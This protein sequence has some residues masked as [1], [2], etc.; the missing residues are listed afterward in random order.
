MRNFT[1][2]G[3]HVFDERQAHLVEGPHGALRHDTRVGETL[4]GFVHCGE[5]FALVLLGHRMPPNVSTDIAPS[6]RD[7]SPGRG[8]VIRAWRR[9]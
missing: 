9:A 2:L 1:F 5:R 4:G 6:V 7:A 8:R 3:W